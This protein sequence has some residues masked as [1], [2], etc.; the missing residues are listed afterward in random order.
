MD[1]GIRIDKWLWAVRLFKT[2]SQA[3]EACKSGNVRIGGQ[4]V[5]ASREV[6][7]GDEI[8]IHLKPVSKK[9]MVAGLIGHRIGPGLVSDYMV[10]LTPEEEYQKLK[11]MK[12]LHFEYRDRGLGRPTKLQRRE[13]ES[14]KRHLGR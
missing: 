1:E 2:R 12:E 6:K 14:L 4:I 11:M 13:I 5:K 8:E 9:V 10:D 3:T 7:P